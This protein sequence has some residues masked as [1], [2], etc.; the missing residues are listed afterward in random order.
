MTDDASAGNDGKARMGRERRLQKAAERRDHDADALERAHEDAQLTL[1]QTLQSFSDLSGKAFRLIRLNAL[2]LTI[3]VAITSQITVSRFVNV[4][5]VAS[6]LL[7]LWSGTAALFAYLTT[8]F[9]RGFE[10]TTFEKAVKYRL[11]K[12]EYLRW[13]LVQGYPKWIAD[14]AEKVNR[15]ELWI[16]R[17]LVAFIAGITALLA[18]ILFTLY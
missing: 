13:V 14:G 6:L 18:G 4:P 2:V 16:R 10:A 5:S 17:S 8:T 11:R 12:T 15:K 1:D 7:F 9:N 3:L